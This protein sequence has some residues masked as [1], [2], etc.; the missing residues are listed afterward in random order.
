MTLI[1]VLLQFSNHYL[2]SHPTFSSFLLFTLSLNLYYKI[3]IINVDL[4]C[5]LSE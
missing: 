5:L 4:T 2:F 1:Y 3:S